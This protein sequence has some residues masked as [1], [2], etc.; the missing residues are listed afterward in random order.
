MKKI[1]IVIITKDRRNLFFQTFKSLLEN[2]DKEKYDLIVVDD[3]SKNNFMLSELF[4]QGHISDLI[5]TNMKSP[6]KCRNLAMEIVKK[7]D[8][9]YVYH[10]DNDMYFLPGWLEKCYKTMESYPEIGLLTPCGHP[11]HLRNNDPLYSIPDNGDIFPVNSCAGNSWFL[12][13]SDYLR[14]GLSEN[15]GIMASEDTEFCNKIRKPTDLDLKYPEKLCVRLKENVVLHCGITNSNG[16]QATG[17]D[18]LIDEL[19]QA[20]IK[21]KINIYYE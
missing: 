17:G 7:R 19:S 21:H 18:I 2:T 20:K 16:E 8:Y 9:K 4:S 13:V 3:G 1:A 12:R 11:Y 15:E 5:L 6:G 14:L 10:S